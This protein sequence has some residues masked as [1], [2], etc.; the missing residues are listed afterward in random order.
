MINKSCNHRFIL[1]VLVGFCSLSS[2]GQLRDDY[3]LYESTSEGLKRAHFKKQLIDKAALLKELESS[4]KNADKVEIISR[5]LTKKAIEGDS[6][7]WTYSIYLRTESYN[8]FWRGSEDNTFEL[9]SLELTFLHTPSLL[10][11]TPTFDGE[12]GIDPLEAFKVC[13]NGKRKMQMIEKLAELVE[14]S[15]ESSFSHIDFETTKPDLEKF[16]YL[17]SAYRGHE[18]VKLMEERLF[19]LEYFRIYARD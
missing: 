17:R 2:L 18:Y 9:L 13:N 19:E 7:I 16:N 15:D 3:T 14:D 1:L 4:F 12:Y 10:E 8:S 11:N 6:M 5:L